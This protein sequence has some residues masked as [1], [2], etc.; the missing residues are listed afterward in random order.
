MTGRRRRRGLGVI[1]AAVT[2][3]LAACGGGGG[4]SVADELDG[5]DD[6]TQNSDGSDSGNADLGDISN[7]CAR[8]GAAFTRALESFDQLTDALSGGTIE[9]DLDELRSDIEAGRDAMPSEVRDAYDTYM[10]AFLAYAE[11]LNGVSPEDFTDPEAVERFSQAA[12]AFG[13]AEVMQATT[14]LTDYFTR[15]CGLSDFAE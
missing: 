3:G 5:T 12:A 13:T 10:D 11:V 6:M 1:A 15:E 14:E 4:S 9:I 2:F 8:A 7:D